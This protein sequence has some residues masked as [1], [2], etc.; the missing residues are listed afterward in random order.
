MDVT[1]YRENEG[2]DDERVEAKCEECCW[3]ETWPGRTS[4]KKVWQDMGIHQMR[5]HRIKLTSG[6]FYGDI[7]REDGTVIKAS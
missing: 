4:I 2:Q 5:C 6:E 3:Q 7:V 1:L